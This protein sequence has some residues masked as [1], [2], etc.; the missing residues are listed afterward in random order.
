MAGGIPVAPTGAGAKNHNIAYLCRVVLIVFLGF[1]LANAFFWWSFPA[2][3]TLFGGAPNGLISP[4]IDK[5]IIEPLAVVVYTMQYPSYLVAQQSPWWDS[6]PTP[7][8]VI[9]TSMIS[10]AIYA[11]LILGL[12]RVV[13]GR[14]TKRCSNRG[15]V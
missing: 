14:K 15:T 4:R 2:W 10:A 8:L 13:R 3:F 11:P 5:W 12:A 1:C 9:T 7:P 6:G